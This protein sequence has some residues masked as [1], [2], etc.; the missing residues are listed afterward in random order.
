MIISDFLLQ[1]TS[2]GSDIIIDI[3]SLPVFPTALKNRESQ[4]I[5]REECLPA[6]LRKA[7]FYS[8]FT[9]LLGFAAIHL[10]AAQGYTLSRTSSHLS[11]MTRQN[12]RR[13]SIFA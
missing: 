12:Y 13:I 7:S 11:A 5:Q 2:W 4:K 10:V 9:M 8:F 6:N 3:S 1:K